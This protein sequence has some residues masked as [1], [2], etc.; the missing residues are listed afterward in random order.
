MIPNVNG[1]GKGEGNG[2]LLQLPGKSHGQRSLVG[3]S[4]WGHKRVRHNLAIKQQQQSSRLVLKDVSITI[5]I[6]ELFVTGKKE[7]NLEAHEEDWVYN[8][9]N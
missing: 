8:L 3:Y 4:P 7:R 6:T 9:I 5:I 1:K 2:N